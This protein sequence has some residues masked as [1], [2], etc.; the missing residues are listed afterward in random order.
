MTGGM[1]N[2]APAQVMVLTGAVMLVLI[3]AVAVVADWGMFFVIQREMQ[4]AA[5]AAALAAVWYSPVC[6]GTSQ[7]WVDAGCQTAG[8]TPRSAC[9]GLRDFACETAFRFALANLGSIVGICDNFNPSTSITASQ[10]GTHANPT[11]N[12]Y[13]VHI[14][15]NA[16]HLMGNVVPNVLPTFLLTANAAATI[17]WRDTNGDVVGD[18][19]VGS[20]PPSPPLI[21]RLVLITS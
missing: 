6:N 19:P 8:P 14:E 10:N 4:S 15:C 16:R 7:T 21:S 18:P 3:G 11:V 9:A 1:R 13:V 17:G 20:P 5:D 12:I 2:R